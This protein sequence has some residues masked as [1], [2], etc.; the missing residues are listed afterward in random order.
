ME[1]INLYLLHCGKTTPAPSLLILQDKY[2]TASGIKYFDVKWIHVPAM[3]LFVCL[4]Q[5]FEPF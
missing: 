1:K 5:A 2:N 4:A 3:P